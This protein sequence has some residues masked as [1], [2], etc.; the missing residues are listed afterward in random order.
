MIW[1]TSDSGNNWF[2]F[3]VAPEPLKRIKALYPHKVIASG[4]DFEYGASC[5]QT[6][7]TGKTWIYDVI[8]P[9]DDTSYFGIGL[10]LAFRTPSEV[11]VPLGFGQAW[12]L[13][14][15]S[16]SKSSPWMKIP[17]PNGESVYDALFINPSFGWACGY[18]GVLL[19]YN[20]GIIGIISN[21]NIIPSNSI[22]FQNY[23]NPFNPLTTISYYIAKSSLV[24]ITVYDITGKEVYKSLEG[25][26]TEGLHKFKF[27]SNHLASG[28]YIYKIDAG[29]FTEAKKMVLFK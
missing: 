23:P 21:E 7:D 13:S 12:A 29:D 18:E 26:R 3:C 8:G 9:H 16:G 10:A 25:F 20:T 4:G 5:V 22:L 19:K 14:L 28:V 11:W 15:D 1:K 24:R 6:V 17:T 27:S 2:T